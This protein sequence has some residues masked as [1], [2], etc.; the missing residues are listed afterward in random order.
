MWTYRESNTKHTKSFLLRWIMTLEMLLEFDL[1]YL[2]HLLI[3]AT[4]N[5]VVFFIGFK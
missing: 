3:T 5:V 1:F 4:I 2:T